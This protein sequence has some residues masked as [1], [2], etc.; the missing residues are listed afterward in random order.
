MGAVHEAT[1]D[2]TTVVR[3]LED[4]ARELRDPRRPSI[5]P[6]VSAASDALTCAAVLL[7]ARQDPADGDLT[8]TDLL[9]DAVALARSAVESAKTACRARTGTRM[10]A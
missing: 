1:A 7:R 9:Y 2:L 8:R 5:P 10:Q 4:L 6:E 3:H